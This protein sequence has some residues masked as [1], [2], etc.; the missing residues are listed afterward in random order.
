MLGYFP[1]IQQVNILNGC[2]GVHGGTLCKQ[3]LLLLLK[4]NAVIV[5]VVWCLVLR[6]A[7]APFRFNICRRYVDGVDLEV[8]MPSRQLGCCEHKLTVVD[9]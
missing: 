7:E 8:P 1:V 9:L 3:F 2:V 5:E 4:V 6:L